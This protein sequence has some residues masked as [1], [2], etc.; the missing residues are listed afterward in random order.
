MAKHNIAGGRGH[1]ARIPAELP[2]LP[3]KNIVVFPYIVAP[4]VIS[5]EE[6][7]KLVDEAL[8]GGKIVGLFLQRDP[9]I[10]QKDDVYDVGTAGQIIKMLRFPD[11]SVRFLVQGVARIK[12]KKFVRKKPYFIAKVERVKET[13]ESSIELEALVRNVLQQFGKVVDLAPYLQDEM[14]VSAMNIEEPSKLA[15]LIASNLNMPV[16]QKQDILGTADVKERLLKLTSYVNRELNILELGSQI[17]RRAASEMGRDQKEYFLREQLKAIQKELGETDQRTEEIEEF[18]KKITA[19]RMPAEALEAARKEMDRLSRISPAAAEYTVARTYLDCLVSLPWSKETVDNLDI[20]TAKEVLD[21]DHYD[22]EKVKERILEYL[23]VRKLKSEMK[24]PILCFVGP[25]GV[26]KTSLGRS[27]ARALGRKFI[28]ISLGGMRDEAEIRGHRRTYVGSLPGRI[29]Q[30]IRRAGS[31]NPIFMLDEI[32]KIGQDFRGDPAAALLEVLDPEQNNSFSDH[33][34][35]V[36][37]DLSR[38]MFITTANI[39]DPIPS[40]LRDRMEVIELPGYTDEEKLHIA[41]KYLVPREREE[42]G[43]RKDQIQFQDEALRE[44]ISRYT[45]EAGLRNLDREIATIYRKVAKR[46]TEGEQGSITIVADNLID[47]L[48][49]V[50]F[51]REMATDEPKVGVVP[52]LAWTQAGGVIMF[53]EATKMPGRKGFTLTGQLGSVM[54]ESAQAALSY[55]RASAKK[56]NIEENFFNKL[57]IHVHV[58]AGAIPKDGPS[59]GITI[60]T[61]LVSLLTDT[62]VKPRLSM[63]GEI[64]LRGEVL[65]IGGVK[66]KTLAAHRAG[67]EEVIMPKKNEKDLVEVPQEVKKKLKFVFVETVDEVFREAFRGALTK[68]SKAKK[69]TKS[70]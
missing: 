53:V 21:E 38:V 13:S 45:I 23:A 50:K 2:V 11:G 7:A 33:Y 44:I 34:L 17:Q 5:Q 9:K 67:I 24:G 40:V 41:K 52:S 22:L 30:G 70:K 39:L 43:L 60:A 3:L 36:P 16:E 65:P 31:K 10:E 46:V 51:F 27:I 49:P 58:P 29:V 47:Y 63:T 35:E 12:I 66:Q 18:R 19:A 59:A 32:D 54:K 15:D 57:D 14:Q 4:L 48:G 6:H 37:F 64:T 69:V 8:V 1:K 42:H 25:P 28:R 68:A 56:L 26:G 61:A 20:P 55:V 62:P